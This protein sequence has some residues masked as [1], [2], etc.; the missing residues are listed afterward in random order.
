MSEEK[1]IVPGAEMT[2]EVQKKEIA[3]NVFLEA[4]ILPVANYAVQQNKIPLVRSVTIRNESDETIE[5]A[6]LYIHSP[7]GV[8][9]P[10]KKL[11]LNIPAGSTFVLDEVKV[12][13]NA[14]HLVYV[15]EQ[16][17]AVLQLTLTVQGETICKELVEI[18]VLAFDQWTGSGLYP[19]LLCSFVTPNQPEI[20]PILK[21]ASAIL[22]EWTGDPQFD[23]Y[24]S[25]DPNRIRSQA[26]AVFEAIK[27]CGIV[28]GITKP[29]FGVPG[30]KIRMVDTVLRD[31]F[32]N[33]L[34]YTLL[35]CACLE[36]IGLHPVIVL[37]ENHAF[38]A[39]WLEKKQFRDPVIYDGSALSK[40]VASGVNEMA[41]VEC[42]HMSSA[43]N[44]SF[45]MA[46]FHAESHLVGE[47]SISRLIDVVC[48]RLHGVRPLPGR[49][50][51]ENGWQLISPEVESESG[52]EE[53]VK[54]PTSEKVTL[55][56]ESNGEEEFSRKRQW[57]RR[58]LDMG[59]RNNLINL[60]MNRNMI[61]ILGANPEALEDYLNDGASF[62]LADRPIDWPI[63]AAD[64]GFE[65]MHETKEFRILIDQSLK[66]GILRTS[67][68]DTALATQL[69]E[70][71]RSARVSLEENGA[72]TLFLAIGLLRWYENEKSVKARYAPVILL[73]VEMVRNQG[74]HGYRVRLRD[75]EAQIN[76][77]M[78]EKLRQ[79]FGIVVSGLDP[80]P[81]DESGLDIRMIFTILRQAIMEQ[82][83]WDVLESSYLGIFS[84]TQFVMWN[85]I[86]N[87]M[88]QLEHNK[89]VSSLL[90]GKLTWDP[91][92]M[93]G[94]QEADRDELY[95]P[96]DLDASQ[97]LAVSASAK[98][99]SFVLH[100]PPGTGKSQ[101]I[102]VMIA[103][104]LAQGKRVLFVAEKMAALEVVQKRL[105]RLGIGPFCLELHSNKSKKREVLEQLRRASEV[106]RK[107]A[108]EAFERKSERLKALRLDLESHKDAL[109]RKTGTGMT[110]YELIDGYCKYKE[111]P[112]LSGRL[113][114][115]PD[116][117][118]AEDLDDNEILVDRMIASAKAVGHPASHPLRFIKGA[119]YTQGL[120]LRFKEREP[121]CQ[122]VFDRADRSA[123]EW[124]NRIDIAVTDRASYDRLKAAS[125]AAVECAKYPEIWCK[126]EDASFVLMQIID[127]AA[128]FAKAEEQ[129]GALLSEWKDGFLDL[130]PA[131]YLDQYHLAAG[132]WA[133]PKML[134]MNKLKK[135]LTPYRNAVW[136]PETI[137]DSL[138]KLSVY[139]KEL[140]SARELMA[141]YGSS[142][143]DLY[144][145]ENTSWQKILDLAKEARES[146]M[147]MD[148]RIG[149]E[150]R[151]RIAKDRG[152]V[153]EAAAF[154]ADEQEAETIW[155]ELSKAFEMAEYEADQNPMASRA[156]RLTLLTKHLDEIKE[157]MM[158]NACCKEACQ[159]G[160]GAFVEACGKGLP[161][162]S[163]KNAYL[164]ACY[165]ELASVAID[166]DPE[167]YR[168]SGVQFGEKVAQ[169]AKLDEEIRN[170][171]AKEIYCK[172]AARVPDFSLEAKA[173]SELGILQRAIRSGGRGITIRRLFEQLP[174]LLP[175][176]CPCM[177]MSPL[178]AA[179]YL[180]PESEPFDL[181]IFDEA[182]Q[183]STGKAVG[184]IAR[185]KDAVI[186]GDPKQM[187]PTS[188]FETNITLEEYEDRDDLESILE[189]CL[190]LN[191]PQ[192]HLLWHYRS[193]HESL[194]AF[195]NHHFYENKLYTF[196]SVND[197]ERKVSLVM[198]GGIFDRGKK[199][200]NP[201]EAAAVVEEILQR[202]HDPA[203][204]E[205][206]LGVVTFNRAQQNLIDDLLG[207]E[208]AKDPELEAW[209]YN[210][211]ESVFIKNL[212]NVQGDERDVILFSIGYGPDRN[213]KVYMNFGPLN[214]E[215]GWRRLNV[216]VSRARYEMKVF[217]SMP[218]ESIDLTKTTSQG[219]AALKAFLEYAGGTVLPESESSI[220]HASIRVPAIAKEIADFLKQE[221]YDTQLCVGKSAFRVEVGVISKA[222]P[223]RYLLGILLDGESYRNAESVR[224]REIAQPGVLKGLGWNTLRIWVMDWWDNPAREKA[225]IKDALEKGPGDGPDSPEPDISSDEIKQ[226]PEQNIP[227]GEKVQISE[228][229]IFSDE[230]T[231]TP[232]SLKREAGSSEHSMTK[233]GVP[234]AAEYRTAD[235]TPMHMDQE[236]FL[237]MDFKPAI[238]NRLRTILEAEAPITYA[239]LCRKLL[240]SVGLGRMNQKLQRRIDS[241]LRM[242]GCVMT[243][244]GDHV[245][246]WK[247]GQDPD[248]FNLF[249]TVSSTEQREAA[250]VPVAEARNAV[251]NALYVNFSMDPESLVRTAAASMGYTRSSAAI[252]E[253]FGEALDLCKMEG[254]IGEGTGDHLVLSDETRAHMG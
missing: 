153:R 176:L 200:D 219:V 237:N 150:L 66:A 95:L 234:G 238:V 82:P 159:A 143:G 53:P 58:L 32:A 239:L 190:A 60:R 129:K 89:I 100:G 230:E 3:G 196:P 178:S 43:L 149:S 214:Q 130:E 116:Q 99:E 33:C 244:S 192:T 146:V 28:Y 11:I 27:E 110:V 78:L 121:I 223:E 189:D 54:A 14:E 94:G 12:L 34:D 185:G 208:C 102:T 249:R 154:L 107:A 117:I 106:T 123:G 182:S 63:P 245:I 105:E 76:I 25:E 4:D 231:R 243:G 111:A 155:E 180:S 1:N 62:V 229:D 205:Q 151:V 188:F 164:R 250:E 36:A 41:V 44:A 165:M 81:G 103:N 217:S 220:M 104:A 88:D 174:N 38:A 242:T 236:S 55:H 233:R 224:D 91:A 73:P 137:E 177:L 157:W 71:Y 221:G 158:W 222:D 7:R 194:I 240:R 30:Q 246:C 10:Y 16:E 162:E 148:E 251:L 179:Q 197:R 90:A 140:A 212:E 198:T 161:I 65:N 193:R 83:R 144:D 136:N 37:T 26:G 183:L 173:S 49:T 225:R 134:G 254:Q 70:L 147:H 126:K 48:S 172:L 18:D 93:K 235:L 72:N 232:E 69:K 210:R 118:T 218:A 77:T 92:N 187:P 195:S 68:S 20:I 131:A 135:Q 204:R 97:L 2:Q 186:V 112:P 59:L 19:E 167:L 98:G 248:T 46:C 29:S 56:V 139:R 113:F 166:D 156:H 203:L 207:E 142:L 228:S 241:S 124:S 22:G 132:K 101:T 8:I 47:D 96:M 67:L 213:G 87:R 181:V 145:G 79:D 170:L 6:E 227:S 215:G 141:V 50:L 75:E 163:A 17:A 13:L 128:H 120:T 184:A 209:V 206:T 191:M 133:L 252:T 64:L 108:P 211:E 21:R 199:A 115:A 119:D 24:Y 202:F 247:K 51:G 80:L 39:F 125:E 216:A 169:F 171:T 23:A 175:R 201:I 109:H 15:T 61:P 86:R 35:Y 52:E 160:L 31:C 152:M 57:E 84:F 40:R 168:F 9:F 122:E 74:N 45:D 85:D 5:E 138:Q 127:M 253:I 114:A 42:T 226:I